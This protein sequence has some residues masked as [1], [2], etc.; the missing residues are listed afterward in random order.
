VFYVAASNFTST[1]STCNTTCRYLEA[2]P[3]S[4]TNAWTDAVYEWSGNT[5]VQIGATAAG[6]AIGTGY[7]NTLAIV[8]QASGGN[9]ANKAATT[10]RAYGGPNNLSDWFLPSKDELNQLYLQRATVGGFVAGTYWSSSENSANSALYQGFTNG[11]PGFTNKNT[12][13]YVRPVRAF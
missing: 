11:T 6:T 7:A 9:T 5:T 2:A 8:G 10:A 1:G 4:G 13:Y 12:T 3:T